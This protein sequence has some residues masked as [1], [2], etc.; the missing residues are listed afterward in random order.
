MKDSILGNAV[1]AFIKNFK[2]NYN[3]NKISNKDKIECKKT[4]RESINKFNNS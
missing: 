2:E 4:I 3:K 1:N